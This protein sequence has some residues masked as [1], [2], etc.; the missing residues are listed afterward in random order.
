M[1]GVRV[2]VQRYVGCCTL[3]TLSMFVYSNF[4]KYENIITKNKRKVGKKLTVKAPKLKIVN[5]QN[6]RGLDEQIPSLQILLPLRRGKNENGR[7]ASFK[8][9]PCN[10]R[11]SCITAASSNHLVNC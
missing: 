11:P 7:V 5:S 6:S 9:Y 3:S 2:S 10:L 8:L 4:L 1:F